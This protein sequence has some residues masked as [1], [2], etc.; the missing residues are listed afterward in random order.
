M[1]LLSK[2]Y[3]NGSQVRFRTTPENVTGEPVRLNASD[4]ADIRGIYWTPNNNAR[5]KVAV[6]ASHPRGDF[7]THHAFPALLAAG[8]GCHG[9]N[10]RSVMN[11]LDCIHEDILLDI[12]RHIRWLKEE[13][14]VEKI[15][16]LGNSGGG[17]LFSFYQSQATAARA[18]RI[19][20][21]PGGR[22][23][24][25][26]E[27][28]LPPGDAL[29][30][31]AAHTGEGV[32]INETI[33]PSVVD[34]E[35]P[36]MTDPALDMYNPA[37]GFREPPQWCK[38]A[39]EF[40]ARYREAQLARMRKL[41]AIAHEMIADNRRAEALH[42]DPGFASLAPEVQRDILQREAFEPI[43]IIYRTMANLNYTDN[44]LDPSERPY[45]SLLSERPHLMNFQRRG[46]ARLHTPHAWLSTWSGLSSNANTRATAPKV[47]IPAVVIQAGRDM[48]V[49]PEEHSKAIFRDLA[50]PDKEYWYF[51]DA[52][53]YFEPEEGQDDT[54]T[55]DELMAR[56]VP[57]VEARAPL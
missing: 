51:P 45:G 46:F 42:A 54:R 27:A 1:R 36:L 28:D 11:D 15:V 31:M 14:G 53:H 6:I 38:Y 37:N 16:L 29:I 9:A 13:R 33:D 40:V 10:M 26:A 17:S 22:P 25:L 56:L 8:Y 5:P 30:F 20:T 47:T 19:A 52:L 2:T 35:R 41:D 12:A 39:P 21:T 7:S 24:R 18:D 23:T 44:T 50:S 43:M 55:L 49:Y 4:G 48:D 57:W 3:W 34:E 32:I